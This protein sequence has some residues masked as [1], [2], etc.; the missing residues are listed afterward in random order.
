MNKS[1]L[2]T[3]LYTC[4]FLFFLNFDFFSLSFKISSCSASPFLALSPAL[5]LPFKRETRVCLNAHA[6]L[7][8][9]FRSTRAHDLSR[10]NFKNC[11]ERR[12]TLGRVFCQKQYARDSVFFLSKTKPLCSSRVDLDQLRQGSGFLENGRIKRLVF[13]LPFRL[14]EL[15]ELPTVF[16]YEA[17]FCRAA[18]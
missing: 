12:P 10:A 7:I 4:Q 6:N 14:K 1:A 11:L 17:V 16:L 18:F 9:A 8:R 13:G 2:F 3:C 15:F 5:G